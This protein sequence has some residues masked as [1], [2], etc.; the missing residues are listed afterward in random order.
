MT[1]RT[2]TLLVIGAILVLM[3]IFIS[4]ITKFILLD[5]YTNLEKQNILRS[6][7]QAVRMLDAE[8]DQIA[9]VVGD[10][11]PW[12]DTYQFVQD[13]NQEYVD[14]NLMDSA[15]INLAVDFL[16][17]LDSENNIVFCKYVDPETE[18]GA[19]CPNSLLT[20]ASSKLSISQ[21]KSSEEVIRG[22]DILPELPIFVAFGPIL[23]SQFKGPAKGTL[24]AGR[25]LT[26]EEVK[27]LAL[28]VNLSVKL[29]RIDTNQLSGDF[30]TARQLLSI[31]DNVTVIELDANTIG[32]YVLLTDIQD[33]PILMLGIDEERLILAQ[34]K[35]SLAYFI[36]AIV[37]TGILFIIVTLLFLE[38]KVLSRISRLGAEV[39]TIGQSGN[40]LKQ[41]TLQG[42][43]EL[44]DLSA[45]INQMIE[46]V[47]VSTERDR[48]ILESIED[49]YFEL[50]LSGRLT[51]YNDSL[52]RL[53]RRSKSDLTGISYRHLLD[54]TFATKTI[55][56]F[57]QLYD[58]DNPIKNL[59]T[60]FTLETGD[61]IFLESTV[62][63]IKDEAG[64]IVGFRGITR[65]VTE[66]KEAAEK[67]IFM[68]YHDSLTGLLNRKA[69]YENLS[70]ELSYA[71]RYSQQRSLLFIDLDDFKKVNDT[72]GHGAGDQLLVEFARRLKQTIRQADQ[73]YRLGGDEFAVVLSDPSS[74]NPEVTAQR[75][76][77][78]M[79]KPFLVGTA[80]ID[81]VTT[82]IGISIF[83]LNGN[84]VET[85]LQ[86][87]DTTMYDAK[88]KKN[89][90]FVAKR[91]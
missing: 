75:I 80:L 21:N 59:E 2:K 30:Y 91:K 83:P 29:Q 86:I 18:E 41:T 40:L 79:H 52:S 23:T 27:R 12:D 61:H 56:A 90:F 28:K 76:I 66:R 22:L 5:G 11:A 33:R 43:D 87:A 84:E 58:T 49:G 65:D 60:G 82:S 9:S 64:K 88:K 14:D 8:L 51:F 57:K 36:I 71:S 26:S 67:L 35:K 44:A 16:V 10:W 48:A 62:T 85:L 70:Q 63:T 19:I 77:D 53:F 7:D 4:T 25:F 34:G 89:T 47:R 15:L 24:V 42:T 3:I 6:A 1:L 81:F 54:R 32:A 78:M 68:V 69:F 55:N 74:Q 13:R 17:F 73:A 37:V 20:Y 45:E 39:K 72:Y 46:S 50:D 31:D 38:M